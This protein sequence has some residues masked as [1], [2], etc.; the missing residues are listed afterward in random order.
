VTTPEPGVYISARQMWDKLCQVS[1][2]VRGIRSDL[3][4]T[5]KS[6]GTQLGDHETRMRALERRV[7]TASGAAAAIGTG[8]G[9]ALQYLSR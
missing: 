1:E 6:H 8:A 7:W 9:Y 5:V 3:K 4:S 2:E